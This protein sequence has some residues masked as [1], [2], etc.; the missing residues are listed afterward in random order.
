MVF[1]TYLFVSYF[2]P[3]VLAAY[4]VVRGLSRRAS[5]SEGRSSLALNTL[6]VLASYV[7]YGWWNPWFIF[8]M[9]GITVLNYVCGRIIG[10]PDVNPCLRR[11]VVTIAIVASLG[12]L[13]FFKYFQFFE[14]NL[15]QVLAWSGAG[16]LRVLAIALPIGIS[17]YTFHA[18]SYTIDVYR[19][20]APPVRSFIDFACYIALFPQ[21]VAGPIIRYNTVADQ[22]VRRD[23]TW[24]K[25]GS[26]VTLFI[27]GFA[28]KIL[29]ANPMGRVA[30]AAFTAEA[31]AAPDAW[32]GALAYALQIYF[33]FSG[34]SDMA[35]GLG[36]MIGFEFMKNFDAPYRAESI[37]DFW[38]RWHISL[39]TFLR[40]YLYI[41]LGGNRKGPRRTY[42]NLIIVML[43]GGLWHGAN[44]TFLAWGAYHG[45]LLALERFRGKRS[46][47]Q[48]WPRPIRV[49]T[50]FVLVLISWVPFR[51]TS[52]G[53]AI[54]YLGAMIGQGRT[55]P[56]M[57]LLP[58]LLYARGTL[59]IMT[60]GVVVVAWP[61]Q[62]HEWSREVT[63]PKAIIVH[64]LFCASL[65]VMFS[66]SF[67]PFLYFQF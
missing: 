43:L 1:T 21:L 40:D 11:A 31:L 25:F 36:R 28:K 15:N 18:L 7:F 38:R 26:G 24:E 67:N 30:D 3:L 4:Y 27:L 22:L 61:I 52:L 57:L 46:A 19:G 34:Y 10:L 56:G 9:L 58:A 63:W 12:A 41:P 13:G 14:T 8:L 39:S 53:A 47:Y 64:P 66:Q 20:T 60:I 65:L 23:H 17:F 62:A 42:V 35:I 16:M 2:L 32:F 37:T 54:D 55:G 29:L 6:L 51:S 45:I 5:D 59:L 33:D 44:W 48:A 50:T 49:A